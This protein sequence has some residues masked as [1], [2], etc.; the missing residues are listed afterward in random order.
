MVGIESDMVDRS[1]VALRSVDGMVDMVDG[2]VDMVR[3]YGRCGGYGGYGRCEEG[4]KGVLVLL[5]SWK[6]SFDPTL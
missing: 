5:D 4:V 3:R 6:Q 2:M 1:V